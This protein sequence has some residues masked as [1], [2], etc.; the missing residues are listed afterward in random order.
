M[1]TFSELIKTGKVKAAYLLKQGALADVSQNLLLI[2]DLDKDSP[3][4]RVF[5]KVESNA[6]KSI[7]V[8]KAVSKDL[9]ILLY[10]ANP[11]I[12]SDE[13]YIADLKD[14]RGQHIDLCNAMI[15]ILTF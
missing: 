2:K 7:E 11:D 10:D 3:N 4:A 6:D 5:S 15:S 14:H 13:D 1:A 12:A 8:M 9:N